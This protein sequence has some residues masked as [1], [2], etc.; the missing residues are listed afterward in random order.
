MS[1]Y[2]KIT[3]DEIVALIERTYNISN[4]N[5]MRTSTEGDRDVYDDFE[6]VEGNLN[7]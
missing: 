7:D 2:L 3:R 4:I 5:W 1:K 6:Y